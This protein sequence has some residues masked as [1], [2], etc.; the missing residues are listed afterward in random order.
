MSRSYLPYLLIIATILGLFGPVLLLDRSFAMRD[1][2][3]FYHPLFEWTTSQW[4]SGKFPLWNPY[5]NCGIPLLADASSSLLYPPKLLFLLPLD[6]N[7]LYKVYVVGHVFWAAWGMFRLGKAWEQSDPASTF[8]AIAYA[9]G[10]NVAFQHCNV[11]FL[12]GA[13]WLPWAL[14]ELTHLLHGN[15]LNW[16]AL[17]RL[18]IVLALMVLGGDPQMAYHV[19]WIQV[20][21]S[22]TAILWRK[23]ISS[24]TLEAATN[25][26]DQGWPVS[27]SLT[28]LVASAILMLGLAAVQFLPSADAAKRSERTCY[29][30][31]RTIGEAVTTLAS[32][33]PTSI[34]A[35]A[36]TSS[37]SVYRGILGTP[38]EGMHHERLYDFS[39]GPWRWAE[40][41]WP[42][43]GGRMFPTQRRWLSYLPAEQRIWTPT[44]YMGLLPVLLGVLG[45]VQAGKNARQSWLRLVLIWFLLGSIGWY[46]IGWCIREI[47]ATLLRQDSSQIPIGSPVGGVYWF[48]VTFLPGYVGFRYPAKLMVVAVAPLCLF[49]AMQFDAL[50]SDVNLRL[51]LRRVAK[52]LLWISIG[53]AVIVAVFWRNMLPA[54]LPADLS[55]GPFDA[56]GAW[57]DI[58]FALSQTAIVLL[59]IRQLVAIEFSKDRTFPDWKLVALTAAELFVANCWIVPSAPANIWRKE[60]AVVRAMH[61]D[62][63]SAS[64][65]N[66]SG[67]VPRF[68]R[69]NLQGWRPVPFRQNASASRMQELTQWDHD[70]LFPKFGLPQ[71]ASAVFSYGSIKPVDF[72]SFFA[73]AD[74]YGPVQ[75]A[76]ESGR[77]WI[78]MPHPAPL[79]L[80]ATEYLIAP[81]AMKPQ[82]GE[83]KPFATSL[84]PD[85]DFGWG[86]E[87][88]LW[89]LDN[90]QPRVWVVRSVEVMDSIEGSHDITQIDARTEAILFPATGEAAKRRTRSFAK[91]A[92][93]ESTSP[94]VHDFAQK[95]KDS[96]SESSPSDKC[97]IT[98]YQTDK[99]QISAELASPGL[100]VLSEAYDPNWVATLTTDGENTAPTPVEILRTNRVVRGILLP[101]GSHTIQMLYAP[102]SFFR[103][104]VVSILFWLVV[105]VWH[106]VNRQQKRGTDSGFRQ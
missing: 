64:P 5:E 69:G 18:G 96:S 53:L 92:V 33:R 73:I 49:A 106:T 9:C 101:A 68:Y 4:R 83:Q 41:I 105:I 21:A 34:S 24:N 2:A 89:R 76:E 15:G 32:T 55:H 72:E 100:L 52:G 102:P 51:R 47:C 48:M 66:T 80:L 58:F 85:Q 30:D 95:L 63:K 1:A 82:Y 43:I 28:V 62:Q 31:P 16:P 11:V 88:G 99:L 84:E 23:R 97:E 93:I 39:I 17:R 74:R 46:G 104:A 10:G 3:H 12:I 25:T 60:S 77:N 79:R 8:A 27:T 81:S 86:G 26:S 75:E 42:N 44:L 13:A 40:F 78:R 57:R 45:L 98:D 35:N 7:L 14:C 91:E 54:R 22:C 36:S 37:P 94:E 71:Q 65:Q 59:F 70:S 103:G 19:L 67:T 50:Q 61:E 38:E 29:R 6:F 87:I 20:L 56:F 90:A